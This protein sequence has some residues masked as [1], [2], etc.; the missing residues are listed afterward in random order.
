MTIRLQLQ[1]LW[2]VCF[3]VML[4]GR[5]HGMKKFIKMMSVG[6]LLLAPPQWAWAT[7]HL[8]LSVALKTL[9]ML[10]HKITGSAIVAIVYNPNNGESKADAIAIKS[11]IDD[12]YVSSGGV[13]LTAKLASTTDLSRN[14]SAFSGARIA[15][16]AHGL[17]VSDYAAVGA[18]ASAAGVLTFCTD[19]NCVKAN[20][21]VL[22][23]ISR[24]QVEVYYSPMAAEA[25]NVSFASAFIM[26]VKQIGTM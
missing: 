9:P 8:D 10:T 11:I 20:V 15:F 19:I 1:R 22:G 13:K 18:A 3:Y 12:G 6:L 26:L 4:L 21:C 16:L 7:D 2:R 5:G 23:V 24:P 14:L 25:S 17:P